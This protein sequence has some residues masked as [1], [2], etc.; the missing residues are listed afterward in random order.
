M[1]AITSDFRVKYLD[2]PKSTPVITFLYKT[3][4]KSHYVQQFG[5]INRRGDQVVAGDLSIPVKNSDKFW[6]I[7]RTSPATNILKTSEIRLGFSGTNEYITLFKGRLETA[8]FN[9]DNVELSF[10]DWFYYFD[11]LKI[12]TEQS[13]VNLFSTEWN[14]ADLVWQLLTVYGGLD[15]TASTLNTDIDYTSWLAWKSYMNTVQ[16]KL[17]AQLIGQSLSETLS[18]IGKLTTSAIYTEGDG[19]IRC[20]FWIGQD[21]INIYSYGESKK[22]DIVVIDIDRTDVA[23]KYVVFYDYTPEIQET[24]TASSGA[25]NKLNDTSKTWTVNAFVNMSVEITFGTGE[26]QKRGI[27]SNTANQLTVDVNW[28]TNPDSTSQYKIT[29]TASFAGSVT[30]QDTGSQ[31]SYGIV[32]NIYNDTFVWHSNLTSADGFAERNLDETIDPAKRCK[33]TTLLQGFAQQIND[34]IRI[35]DTLHELSNQGMHVESLN[36]DL[37]NMRVDITGRLADLFHFLILDHATYG[38]LDDVNGLI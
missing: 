2:A 36:F 11:M 20:V 5:T 26:G 3:T 38:V 12:G 30:K 25:S 18:A 22:T 9:A 16:Y 35:T 21:T 34:G 37:E 32:E 1:I 28:N 33:F 27:I 6:N 13:P 4:N 10:K 24:G 23:N 15:S 7:I 29:S 17:K 8:R 31:T 14:P 19:K